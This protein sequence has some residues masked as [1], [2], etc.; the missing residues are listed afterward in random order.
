MIASFAIEDSNLPFGL[1]TPLPFYIYKYVILIGYIVSSFLT[2]TIFRFSQMYYI[3]MLLL[4][5]SYPPTAS[6]E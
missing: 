1:D 4:P 2:D 3:I 5:V 6:G